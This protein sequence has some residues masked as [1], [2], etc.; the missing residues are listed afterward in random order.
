MHTEREQ[1]RCQWIPLVKTCPTYDSTGPKI[2]LCLVF[3][4]GHDPL[5]H[6]WEMLL[7]F[8]E[9]MISVHLII[10]IYQIQLHQ[11]S[12]LV[13]LHPLP[14]CVNY[15]FNAS[16]HSYPHLVRAKKVG[17]FFGQLPTDT[18]G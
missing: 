1:K 15:S 8:F 14:Y 3:V 11:K 9:C 12:I 17:C 13:L 4:A 2:K 5:Q 18:F 16:P 7:N 6:F 10:C